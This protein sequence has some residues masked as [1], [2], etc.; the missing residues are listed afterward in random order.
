MLQTNRSWRLLIGL[1]I[2]TSGCSEDTSIRSYQVA[3]NQSVVP[4]IAEIKPARILGM[5]VPHD[6]SAWFLKLT[7][8]PEQVQK[9]DGDFRKLA[10]SISFGDDGSPRWQLTEGWSEQVL[11]QIT[12]A[13][14]SH[15]DGAIVTL[16]QLGANTKDADQWQRYL[17][18]NINRWREQLSLAPADWPA[19]ET[20]LEEV[21]SH[22]TETAKAYF[23][24]LTGKQSSGGSSMAP[25]APFANRSQV[26][27]APNDEI[28]SG[29]GVASVEQSSAA[30]PAS[31]RPKL[32]YEN[33][34][35]WQEQP[36]SGIRLAHFEIPGEPS[37]ATVSISTAGGDIEQS[38]GMWLQ[39]IGDEADESR[40]QQIV[41][42]ATS[43][44]SKLGEYRCYT[45]A[46]GDEAE[47]QSA[48]AIRVAVIPI[49]PRESLF[50]KLTGSKEQIESLKE[51]MDQLI[52]SLQW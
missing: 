36:S 11:R 4:P 51:P 33:P 26:S 37:K 47:G 27:Q 44:E 13:K 18:D 24:S 2:L 35:G 29:A 23:I 32:T 21:P 39:Q 38:V 17:K 49:S 8:Q 34:E 50:V 15:P 42:S 41:D 19:I 52:A 14:F 10:Q 48:I 12:Y 5:I 28:H 45:I 1:L 3:K 16:T 43:A 6:E 22:S 20:E 31:T 40:I 46:G 7:D 30:E 9:L 25:F